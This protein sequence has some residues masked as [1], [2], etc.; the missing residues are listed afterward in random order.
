MGI[1][2]YRTQNND[3]LPK[4]N[5]KQVSIEKCF[6]IELLSFADK[7]YLV[8]KSLDH[9]FPQNIHNVPSIDKYAKNVEAT[10]SACQSKYCF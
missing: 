10:K 1:R 6:S 9:F 7:S 8:S 2:K 4:V 5:T 3:Y